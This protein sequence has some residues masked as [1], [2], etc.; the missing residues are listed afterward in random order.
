VLVDSV[1]MEKGAA[2]RLGDADP[3]EVVRL[4][5]QRDR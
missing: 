5:D 3:F 2:R 1:V 4:G